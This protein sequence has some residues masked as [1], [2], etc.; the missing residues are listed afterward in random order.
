MYRCSSNCKKY[1]QKENCPYYLYKYNY[2]TGATL[3]YCY[4]SKALNFFSLLRHSQEYIR[5]YVLN[6]LQAEKDKFMERI[7]STKNIDG[8]VLPA[9]HPMKNEVSPNKTDISADKNGKNRVVAAPAVSP[10]SNNE[11]ILSKLITL[12]SSQNKTTQMLIENHFSPTNISIAQ[13]QTGTVLDIMNQLTRGEN[14]SQEDLQNL[15]DFP[16]KK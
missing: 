7:V 12:A 5:Y 2:E 13:E 3:E 6:K 9:A 11:T 4:R 15:L 14:V 1:G 16:E 8:A 10:S